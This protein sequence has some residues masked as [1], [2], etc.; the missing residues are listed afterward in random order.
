MVVFEC[1]FP[2]FFK[3]FEHYLD[4]LQWSCLFSGKKEGKMKGRGKYIKEI[5]HYESRVDGRWVAEWK[6]F[7]TLGMKEKM[8]WTTW[9]GDERVG[10]LPLA[11]NGINLGNEAWCFFFQISRSDMSNSLRPMDRSMPGLPVHHQLP[12]FTQIHVHWVGDAVQPSHPVSPT[13]PQAFSLSQHQGLFFLKPYIKFSVD[14][15]L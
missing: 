2:P 12:E 10:R 8:N 4:F 13:S 15:L 5:F 14:I 3:F 9:T 11:V 7:V 6:S 1:P